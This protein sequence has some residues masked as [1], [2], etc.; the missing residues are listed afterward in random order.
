MSL[1]IRKYWSRSYPWYLALLTSTLGCLANEELPRNTLQ[2]ITI[3]WPSVTVRE[4]YF[5]K[6][7]P[8]AVSKLASLLTVSSDDSV[9]LTSCA[10]VFHYPRKSIHIQTGWTITGHCWPS[11]ATPGLLNHW[12]PIINHDEESL[13]G[14]WLG[15]PSH[16]PHI[17]VIQIIVLRYG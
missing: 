12:K 4:N 2:L 14:C 16:N 8:W 6:I 1:S 11:L 5:M 15:V 13:T 7:T 9:K 10:F 17:L 3:S